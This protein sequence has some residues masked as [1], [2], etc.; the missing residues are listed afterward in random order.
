[1]S[2]KN[3]YVFAKIVTWG[4]LLAKI[5]T[6]VEDASPTCFKALV[7]L[8]DKPY[9]VRAYTLLRHRVFKNGLVRNLGTLAVV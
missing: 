1:M 8:H 5:I 7:G 3:R 6:P 4:W 2:C 9:P